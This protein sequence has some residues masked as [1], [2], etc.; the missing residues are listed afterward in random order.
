MGA[1]NDITVVAGGLAAGVLGISGDGRAADVVAVTGLQA[2]VE[3]TILDGDLDADLTLALDDATGT[4]DA[5]TINL[6]E[7]DGFD[8][9]V[10]DLTVSGVETI[11]FSITA[12]DDDDTVDDVEITDL[13]VDDAETV[14]IVSEED[15][16][17]S[18]TDTNALVTIDATGAVAGLDIDLDGSADDTGVE[19]LLANSNSTAT[20]IA[21]TLDATDGGSDSIV[22]NDT[23]VGAITVANFDAGNG[24]VKDVIDLSAYGVTS[25]DDL[26][27]GGGANVTIDIDDDDNFGLITLTGVTEATLVADN[28]IFA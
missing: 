20:V 13:S 3:V 24:L 18:F 19:I 5:L 23:T 10:A 21:I 17:I 22:V 4:S 8:T 27:F 26:T 15:V 9:V 2:G 6:V 1:G 7:A 11:T 25:L 16:D 28:F 12:D 14:V